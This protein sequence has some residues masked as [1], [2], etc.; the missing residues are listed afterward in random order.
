M[1]D[2]RLTAGDSSHG[3]RIR[4]L[5]VEDDVDFR[6]LISRFLIRENDSME[7]HT[8]ASAREGFDYLTDNPVDCVVSDYD[9]P[10]RDG[11]EF[12]DDVRD[13]DANLPFILFTGKGSEEIASRAISSGVTDY[14]QKGGSEKYTLLANRIQA[15]VEK[16]RTAEQ[17]NTL[18][19]RYEL[20]GKVA[21]DAF[22]EKDLATRTVVR[23]QGYSTNFGYDP[24][25]IGADEDWWRAKIHPED[26]E[27]VMNVVEATI[28]AGDREFKTTYRFQ[29]ADGSYGYVEDRG[30]I[31]YDEQGTPSRV[32]GTLTDITEKRERKNEL[33]SAKK[34][35]ELAL[36]AS[37]IGIWE[38]D[39]ATNRL[40]W[41]DQ[42][43]RIF[44]VTADTFDGCFDDFMDR[45]HPADVD[46]VE[47]AIAAAVERDDRYRAVFRIVPDDGSPQWV[48]ARGQAIVDSDGNQTKMIGTIKPVEETAEEDHAVSRNV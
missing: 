41:D 6:D 9:M 29:M 44:G 40:Y 22:Y 20:V 47:S 23:S 13:L 45:V 17:L 27:R 39:W 26:K 34:R 8:A 15:A 2:G 24:D 38:W 43:K 37:E 33:G 14:V 7:V 10:N 3:E 35:L 46:A 21:T 25:D 19:R 42:V 30:T 16:Y 28:D 11:L 31:V 48:E 1:G 5:I 12:L 32:V 18:R 36:E 4:V